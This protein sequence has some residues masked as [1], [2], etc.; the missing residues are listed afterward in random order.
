MMQRIKT[1]LD[2]IRQD[3]PFI[4][5]L[6][7]DDTREGLKDYL[8]ECSK[9]RSI[10]IEYDAKENKSFLGYWIN[11]VYKHYDQEAPDEIKDII[12]IGVNITKVGIFTTSLLLG[13]GA[14]IIL[15]FLGG[16]ITIGEKI[17]EKK[18]KNNS[19]NRKEEI[20]ANALKL[21]T[22]QRKN[23]L[24]PE[25]LV[26][27]GIRLLYEL[28]KITRMVFHIKNPEYLSTL[29]IQFLRQYYNLFKDK[30]SRIRFSKEV[31][32]YA[33]KHT[34]EA[35]T[36]VLTIFD[37]KDEDPREWNDFVEKENLQNCM[38]FRWFLRRYKMVDDLHGDIL[39]QVVSEDVF[40]G[41]VK[42]LDEL[43]NDLRQALCEKTIK[44]RRIQG[45]SGMGKT[46]LAK[47]FINEILSNNWVMPVTILQS[48]YSGENIKI[49]GGLTEI[50]SALNNLK[51]K[52][53][54][55]FKKEIKKKLIEAYKT[56]ANFWEYA[57]DKFSLGC[58]AESIITPVV[59]MAGGNLGLVG[60]IIGT[61]GGIN[62][63]AQT[64][65]TSLDRFLRK[66]K[67]IVKADESTKSINIIIDNLFRDFCNSCEKNKMR[68]GLVWIIDD[69]QWMD[70]DS[71]TYFN[72]ILESK[73]FSEIPIYIVFLERPSDFVSRIKSDKEKDKLVKMQ[74]LLSKYTVKLDGFV[75][76]DI[77]SILNQCIQGDAE[78]AALIAKNLWKW[79][80]NEDNDRTIEPL[81]LV[82]S[83]NLLA[84]QEDDYK[85]LIFDNE[86][87]QWKWVKDNLEQIDKKIKSILYRWNLQSKKEFKE[88]GFTPSGVAVMEERLHRLQ[89]HFNKEKGEILLS[90]LEIGAFIGE[91]FILQAVK[92]YLQNTEKFNFYVDADLEDIENSYGIILKYNNDI[93]NDRLLAYIYSHSLYKQYMVIRFYKNNE[94]IKQIHSKVFD[95]LHNIIKRKDISSKILTHIYEQ[96]V[97]HAI[98]S[99]EAKIFKK[100]IN[101]ALYLA[102][103]EDKSLQPRKQLSYFQK[104]LLLC[105]GSQEDSTLILNFIRANLGRLYYELGEYNL[106]LDLVSQ[107]ISELNDDEYDLVIFKQLEC[108]LLSGLSKFREASEKGIELLKLIENKYGKDS[109]QYKIT[110]DN[111][112]HILMNLNKAEEAREIQ[113]ELVKWS[114]KEHGNEDSETLIY[115]D[116]LASTYR[117]LGYCEEALDLEH[118]VYKLAK[119]VWGEKSH[120]TLTN[121]A[122][123]CD[124]YLQIREYDK[125]LEIS[126]EAYKIAVSIYSERHPLSLRIMSGMAVSYR[127]KGLLD[128]ALRLSLKIV[129]IKEGFLGQEH[130]ETIISKNN[131]SRVYIDLKML[132]KAEPIQKEIVEIMENGYPINI[133]DKIVCL[134]IMQEIY[135]GLEK[136]GEAKK[137]MNKILRLYK[138]VPDTH[139]VKL[140]SSF[141]NALLY[142]KQKE[143]DKTIEILE[144]II[145]TINNN[146]L[147]FEAETEYICAI[148]L[149]L[150]IFFKQKRDK[151][152]IEI[153]EKVLVNKGV[154]LDM[155]SKIDIF[156]YL[157]FAYMRTN[158][159]EAAMEIVNRCIDY[160]NRIT[161][162]DYKK[163]AECIYLKGLIYRKT[164]DYDAAFSLCK[165]AEQIYIDNNDSNSYT[166]YDILI[167]ISMIYMFKNDWL[168][169][170]RNQRKA[171]ELGD[172]I[173]KKSDRD[174]IV[175]RERL[176]NYYGRLDNWG[177]GKKVI[178]EAIEL[179]EKYYPNDSELI[180][181]LTQEYEYF[182]NQSEEDLK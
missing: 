7:P 182:C 161:D 173:L 20:A 77:Y 97:E 142:H 48:S 179:A 141:E 91:P 64:L 125:A 126:Q 134:Q 140:R 12:K 176:A 33:D 72:R 68:N 122:N 13:N 51:L 61:A 124:T 177:R 118:Q 137:I 104:A 115:K 3:I 56:N 65:Q 69:M 159:F 98:A 105:Q 55:S 153:A 45:N 87:G 32:D 109:E 121:M 148:K 39:N 41:R 150:E 123:I 145:N 22:K 117:T 23:L 63:I 171:I 62:D 101:Y 120:H 70:I 94:D 78:K 169:A 168:Y 43:K 131:L 110:M 106:G 57:K 82:E 146:N 73:F 25:L 4:Y 18:I 92:I 83:I 95:S 26:L 178:K 28:S 144:Y 156:Y 24:R 81:F 54:I 103:N 80:V 19:E 102:I 89:K 107:V 35:K 67:P 119:S 75:M 36:H 30:S 154:N 58:D 52:T 6:Y 14:P 116:N 40:V 149:L 163:I 181:L 37:W 174:R 17:A 76:E 128:E 112:A 9:N 99:Q 10:I 180:D 66:R 50:R 38:K 151:N 158:D 16:G 5:E 8:E 84:E 15:S 86:A 31:E 93:I 100:A 132:E 60:Q 172:T 127:G 88:Y 138:Y 155:E 165:K 175:Q 44:I 167:E 27:G 34:K 11:D 71:I 170:A 129:E 79:F 47:K 90:L 85:L 96:A 59:E 113:E 143:I 133:Y 160:F 162:A 135:K 114:V 130:I 147:Y 1:E 136:Y 139:I 166:R 157:S 152:I 108:Q 111:Q 53:D 49:R 29:D 21:F 42:I 2:K 164:K 46:T 74:G